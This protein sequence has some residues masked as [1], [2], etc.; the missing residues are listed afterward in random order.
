MPAYV[1]VSCRCPRESED[2]LSCFIIESITHAL[3]AESADDHVVVKFYLPG[4]VD[5]EEKVQILRDYLLRKQILPLQLLPQAIRVSAIDEMD[6]IKVYQES[7]VPVT[8][9]DIVVKTPWD[10]NECPGKLTLVIE[11]KMAFGTG[12]HETTQLCLAQLRSDVKRGH[13]VL[14]FGVGSG[15]LSILAVKLGALECLGIDN[16]PIAIDN[17]HEAILLNGVADQIVVKLGSMEQVTRESYYDVVVSNLSRDGIIDLYDDFKKVARPGGV[18]IL[19]G[20]SANQE[21]E[22]VAFLHQKGDNDIIVTRK[23]EWICFRVKV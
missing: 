1:E 9:G 22:L 10:N 6:W 14:D 8:I 12:H 3:V 23:N 4:D 16:D 19:A 5:A 21:D 13:K 7:F 18:V 20:A 17:A 2:Q 15:I 11:P